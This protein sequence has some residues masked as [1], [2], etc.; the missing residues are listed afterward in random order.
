MPALAPADPQRALVAHLVE[1]AAEALMVDARRILERGRGGSPDLHLARHLVRY[2]LLE[3]YHLGATRIGALVGAETSSIYNSR[4]TI[5]AALRNGDRRIE[6]LVAYVSEPP[7]LAAPA[8]ADDIAYL[9][10]VDR[11]AGEIERVASATAEAMR[12]LAR[13][14]GDVRRVAHSAEG[15]IAARAQLTRA[16]LATLYPDLLHGADP[17]SRVES[18]AA[19]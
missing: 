13:V 4:S 15:V 1:R 14:A 16:E 7:P 12:L 17:E 9:R 6:A 10:S 18:E 5:E 19:G 3:Q 8:V 2:A 11:L